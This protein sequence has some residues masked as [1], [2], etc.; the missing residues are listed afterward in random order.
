MIAVLC[1]KSAELS[2][3]KT[4]Q[5]PSF[6]KNAL[7]PGSAER[8]RL[9]SRDRISGFNA[10]SIVLGGVGRK[11][12]LQVRFAQYLC[13]LPFRNP[14]QSKAASK[15][16]STQQRDQ[17]APRHRVSK[18]PSQRCASSGISGTRTMRPMNEVQGFSAIG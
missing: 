15:I 5:S 18:I 14:D 17:I 12:L 10:P 6:K 1:A 16:A 11:D 3:P 7:S 2:R 8:G 4:L 13:H 9:W